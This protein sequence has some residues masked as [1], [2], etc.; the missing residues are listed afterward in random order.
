MKH[1]RKWSVRFHPAGAALFLAALLFAPSHMVLA[2]AAALLWHEAAHAAAMA[3]AGIK[4]CTIEITPFGGMID[5]PEINRLSPP[6]QALCALS[7]IAGSMAGAWLCWRFWRSSFGFA[8]FQSHL[9]LMLVNCLPAWPLDGARML[10]AFAAIIG[11]EKGMRKVLRFLSSLLAILFACL[12]L[13]GAW[14]GE[15]N[16][17]L[18]LCGPYLA[19]AS[20]NGMASEQ[21]RQISAVRSKSRKILPV[22]LEAGVNTEIEKQFP[23]RIAK[24]NPHQ[25]HLL[26]EIDS[27][28]KLQHI[29]T[30]EEIWKSVLEEIDT[31]VK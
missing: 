7:G 26:C 23:S 27:E 19:Y 24:W 30:E 16:L 18:M 14:H 2:A 17:S 6:K 11:C 22:Q 12:G 1:G 31:S 29:W 21:I 9:S 4:H 20:K 15:V 13:Y 28:G 3:C 8:L 25:Y 10:V 5:A